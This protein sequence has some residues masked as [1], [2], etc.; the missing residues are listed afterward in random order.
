MHV[1]HVANVF[2]YSQTYPFFF[3]CKLLAPLPPYETRRVTFS[4]LFS[5]FASKKTIQGIKHIFKKKKKKW[6][7][8]Q[9]FEYPLLETSFEQNSVSPR[10][11]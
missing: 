2:S 8:V 10:L 3:S 6:I 7:H 11:D 1:L 4:K 9:I 5:H